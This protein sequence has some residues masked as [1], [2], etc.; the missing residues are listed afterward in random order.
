MG[1]DVHNTIKIYADLQPTV[2][3][4]GEHHRGLGMGWQVNTFVLLSV[5]KETCF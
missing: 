2:V 5:M 1:S 3:T 4:D